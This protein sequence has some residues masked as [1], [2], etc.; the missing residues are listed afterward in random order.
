[1]TP[2][3][4]DIDRARRLVL[5]YGWNATAY[6][7][8]NPGMR[9]W[10]SAA[11]DAVVGYVHAHG[12]RVAGGVPV[13]ATERLAATTAEFA[14]DAAR[15][16]RRVCWFA[17]QDRFLNKAVAAGPRSVLMIGAQPSWDARRWREIVSGKAS[18][19]AQFARAKNKGVRV[20]QWSSESAG[21]QEALRRCLRAWLHS[22]GLPP[23]HFLVEWNLLPRLYDRRLFV[24][25]HHGDPVGYLIASPIPLRKGWLVEQTVRG[26][27]APNG[28]SELL[29]D[30]AIEALSREGASYVTL[31]LAPLSQTLPPPS[32]PPWHVRGLLAWTRAHGR[33]FYNFRG[34]ERFKAKFLPTRWEPIYAVAHDRPISLDTLYAITGAF[35]GT[36]PLV[37]LGRALLRDAAREARWVASVA[38]QHLAKR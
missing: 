24:A 31:G 15:A 32:Q 14:E 19:R 13:C 29:L 18:L 20:E 38:Y 1:M 22:R 25:E 23:M 35:G 12:Y 30:S 8:L 3:A 26:P 5:R 28:T 7:L 27:A 2:P 10:F 34:L 4:Q 37:F 36:S 9:L 17:A 6:Q 21:E 16:G 33:R 11:G